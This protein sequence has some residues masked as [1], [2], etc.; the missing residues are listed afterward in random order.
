MRTP[1]SHE[2]R[3]RMPTYLR[4]VR[5]GAGA[6]R[7]TALG[8]PWPPPRV[9]A[10]RPRQVRQ[11]TARVGH[12]IGPRLM[13]ETGLPTGAAILFRRNAPPGRPLRRGFFVYADTLGR[14]WS[15]LFALVLAPPAP[16]KIGYCRRSSSVS[17]VSKVRRGAS[18]AAPPCPFRVNQATCQPA[19]R[20]PCTSE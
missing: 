10:R 19:A 17:H 16:G 3:V 7:A 14:S 13:Q 11:R 15:G 12:R 4:G 20:P 9:H 5:R 8:R 1:L 18:S 6:S 2:R